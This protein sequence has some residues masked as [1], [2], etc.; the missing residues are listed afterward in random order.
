MTQ[1]TTTGSQ[2]GISIGARRRRFVLQQPIETPDGFGGVLR[3]FADGPVVWGTIERL[4]SVEAV[5]GGRG[6]RRTTHRITLRYRPG[7]DARMR[8]ASGPRRFTIREAGDPDGRC[9]DLVC[10][11]EEMI[12]AAP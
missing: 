6:D 1:T 9:R 7:V 12:E 5:S 4:G 3:Q 8:L 2:P 11:V 10:D